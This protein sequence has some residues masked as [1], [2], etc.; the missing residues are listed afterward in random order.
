MIGE[1]GGSAEEEA[2]AWIRANLKKPVV[3]FIAGRTAPPGRRMG[4]AGAII[5]GG[6]GTAA[7][8]V[9]ALKEAGV[10]VADSP[11]LMGE[12]LK[13]ILPGRDQ[14]PGTGRPGGAR[15]PPAAPPRGGVAAAPVRA[16]LRA[17]DRRVLRRPEPHGRGL[18]GGLPAG[19]G[20]G[21]PRALSRAREGGPRALRAVRV[22]PPAPSARRRSLLGI[23]LFFRLASRAL[24][25]FPRPWPT[26]LLSV[27]YFPLRFSAEVKP[28]SLDL[29]AA[30]VLLDLGLRV[31]EDPGRLR[32]LGLLVL[33]A[34]L[35]RRPLVPELP[36]RRVGERRPPARRSAG[37]PAAGESAL[38]GVQPRRRS[39]RSSRRSCWSGSG[40]SAGRGGS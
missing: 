39:P 3:S 24:P 10:H 31:R 28:Y 36:R 32:P 33:V 6:K 13:K 15:R 7:E 1:I 38:R 17:L 21:R 23:V 37:T 40:S 5:S 18:G 2:A 12:T 9:K 29:L 27:S 30:V 22:R 14:P 20:A 34:P 26:G 16:E 4:H 35:A 8:K 25:P 11:A 19:E